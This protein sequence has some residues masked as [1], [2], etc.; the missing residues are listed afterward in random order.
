MLALAVKAI[1]KRRNG[2]GG[3]SNEDFESPSKKFRE[4]FK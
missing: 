2:N 1:S 4:M 3:S